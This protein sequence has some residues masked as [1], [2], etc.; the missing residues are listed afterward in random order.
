MRKFTGLIVVA[1]IHSHLVLLVVLLGESQVA[2]ELRIHL[3]QNAVN[4]ELKWL[5]LLKNT[6]S[7]EGLGRHVTGLLDAVSVS[8]VGLVASGVVLS[9]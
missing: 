9:L 3:L 4:K 8:L 7:L 2:Q 1:I 6:Y 5:T